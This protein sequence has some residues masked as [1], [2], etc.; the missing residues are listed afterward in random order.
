MGANMKHYTEDGLYSGKTHKMDNGSLHT[1]ETHTKTS[2]VVSHKKGG[3]FEMKGYSY[4]GESPMTKKKGRDG[5]AC[6]KGYT[7]RGTKKKGGR[8]VDNCVKVKRRKK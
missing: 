7:L 4:P 2:K 6:W 8:T 3:P 5:K 1:G